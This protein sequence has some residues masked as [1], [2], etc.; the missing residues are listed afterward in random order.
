ML[1]FGEVRS[2]VHAVKSARPVDRPYLVVELADDYAAMLED[3]ED[4][5]GRYIVDNLYNLSPQ[6]DLLFQTALSSKAR[7]LD[8]MFGWVGLN[9][10]ERRADV[11]DPWESA[12]W[13]GNFIQTID[14]MVDKS[15]PA[16]FAYVAAR[17][18]RTEV[19]G[20]PV[21]ELVRWVEAGVSVL[22]V[23][24]GFK[25]RHAYLSEFLSL[26]A[27]H[28]LKRPTVSPALSVRGTAYVDKKR[29]RAYEAE[30]E[31]DTWCMEFRDA[32]NSPLPYP[33]TCP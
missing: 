22:P 17:F 23:R 19:N 4:V 28:T 33:P 16:M 13:R 26:W 6:L 9:R 31:P 11:V 3:V 2:L 24:L 8:A 7:Q 30:G 12:L 25:G 14:S 29:L 15:G 1:D 5:A 27:W 32:D 21:G 10:D 20:V 18:D